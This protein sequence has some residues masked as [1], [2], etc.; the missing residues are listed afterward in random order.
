MMVFLARPVGYLFPSGVEIF[1]WQEHI[2]SKGFL[3]TLATIRTHSPIW[4][5]ILRLT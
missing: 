2:C 1:A 5:F 3:S 4:G